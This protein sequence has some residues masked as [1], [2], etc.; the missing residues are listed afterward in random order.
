M[1]SIQI[2]SRVGQALFQVCRTRTKPIIAFL[3]H[4]RYNFRT[5]HLNT[6]AEQS[7]IADALSCLG[8]PGITAGRSLSSAVFNFPVV[9]LKLVA[10]V[11]KRSFVERLLAKSFHQSLTVL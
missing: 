4:L 3:F 2:V 7:H 8:A 5:Q 6:A 11:S 10:P 1:I 9:V